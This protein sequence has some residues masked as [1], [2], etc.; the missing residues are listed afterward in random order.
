MLTIS[1]VIVGQRRFTPGTP[2]LTAVD[3]TLAF[4]DFQLLKLK[5]DKPLSSFAFK[6]KLGHYA[7]DANGG[8]APRCMFAV[9]DT[10]V[11]INTQVWRCSLTPGSPQVDPRFTPLGINA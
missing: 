6:C 3:P 5:H 1:H 2:W 8:G 11:G 10:G 4:R 9:S 7:P